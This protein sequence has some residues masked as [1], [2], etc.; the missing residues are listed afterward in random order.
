MRFLLL[1]LLVHLIPLGV[2][3][4]YLTPSRNPG[5]RPVALPVALNVGTAST[6]PRNGGRP[7]LAKSDSMSSE[8]SA[9]ATTGGPQI[10][11]HSYGDLLRARVEAALDYPLSVR[12]RRLT[13]I[14]QVR[15]TLGSDGSL[16][17]TEIAQSSGSQELDSLALAA[18]SAAAPFPDPAPELKKMGRFVVNLPIEFR[19]R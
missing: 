10:A 5:P 8:A 19:L 12:R 3:S 13:G 15:I 6:Q 1:S 9:P 7:R 18:V 14:S 2:L 17:S 16:V 4:Y 11:E